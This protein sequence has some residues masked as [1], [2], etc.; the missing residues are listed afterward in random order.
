MLVKTLNSIAGVRCHGELLG[1]NKVRGFEDGV[2][3]EHTSA[4]ER[5]A[6]EQRL[7]ELRNA[8][9]LQFLHDAMCGA[10]AATGFKMIYSTLALPQWEN[11]INALLQDDSMR[12]IHLARRNNLRRYISEEIANSGGPIH[13]G[14]GGRA[15]VPTQITVD[16]AAFL[17]NNAQVEAEHAAVAARLS[18]GSTLNVT[19]EGLSTDTAATLR[20]VCRFLGVDLGTQEIKPALK[21]VGAKDLSDTVSN[22]QELLDH[23]QTR[24]MAL[25]D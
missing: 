17:A 12:Y 11:A 21:K 9:P 22:F 3:L 25:S 15:E 2:D 20:Q 10:E 13:S 19:Y 5:R 1:P 4:E 7:L 6:R 8:N 23:P 18:E 16:I 14:P 24:A